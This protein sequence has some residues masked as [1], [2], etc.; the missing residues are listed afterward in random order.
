M[1]N[2]TAEFHG[3]TVTILDHLN[4][5][6]LTAR[7]VGR[8]LG[9]AEA[10]A[11]NSVN[12]LHS[13]HADEFGADDQE[14]VNLAT[15]EFPVKSTGNSRG[16]PNT[17]IFSQTGCILLAMFAN[18]A[19]AK[20][21][22][23]WAKQ[24]LAG[25]AV[26]AADWPEP[27]FRGVRVTRTVERQ[28][29]EMFV[30]GLSL[31]Q[32]GRHLGISKT[33]ASRLISGKYRFGPGAGRDEITPQLIAAVTARHVADEEARIAERFCASAANQALVQSMDRAGQRLLA[34]IGAEA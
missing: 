25:L 31:S 2:L 9:Y 11:S 22:R 34:A 26:E 20:D 24:A 16:N 23:A 18:T 13:R 32:I 14:V 17:R 1:H 15:P 21:F 33:V 27:Y 8:C 19:R 12:R 6:W 30:A 29:L 5:R 7:D 28:C 10:E 3:T 4:R